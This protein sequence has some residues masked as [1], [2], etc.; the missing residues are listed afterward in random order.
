MAVEGT[1]VYSRGLNFGFVHELK[2]CCMTIKKHEKATLISPTYYLMT[3][4][5]KAGV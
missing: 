2:F 3:G 4:L 5:S 1:I